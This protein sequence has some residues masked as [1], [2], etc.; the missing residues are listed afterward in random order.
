[1]MNAQD[2]KD[3]H[4]SP[5]PAVGTRLDWVSLPQQLRTRIEQWL[6]SPVISAVSQRSGFS[7][8][9]AARLQLKEGRHIFVKAVGTQPNP[10]APDIHR[11]EA[12]ISAALPEGAPVPRL[13]WAYDDAESGWVVLLFENIEGQP[14]AQ[15]WH[16]DELDRVLN[17]MSELA[18]A[19]TPS[20][21]PADSIGTASDQFAT[22]WNGWQRLLEHMPDQLDLWSK[23]HLKIL[24]EREA[25]APAAVAGK[26]LLHF[27]IRADN[28]LLSPDQ[29]W[30]VDWPLACVGADWV[31]VVLFAPSIHM[32]GGPTPEQ[33]LAQYPL[34]HNA[35]PEA[36]TTAIIATAGFFTY[37]A[38]QPPPPGIPTVRAFQAAQGVVAREWIAQR[39]GWT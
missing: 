16:P 1:M 7:P 12:Q 2:A 36:V 6:G 34:I 21:L 14:P 39:T 15:P 28:I 20:P 8:G 33:L 24:A 25:Y 31:D 38:L 30:F 32:Q 4:R 35:D 13:L 5:P 37:S 29:V 26:T 22:R 23:H 18:L 3:K 27:D 9:V 10:Q 11:R 17:A 19:M